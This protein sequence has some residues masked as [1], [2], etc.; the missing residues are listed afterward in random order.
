MRRIHRGLIKRI[1]REFHVWKVLEEEFHS[2]LEYIRV[3]SYTEKSITDIL[4]QGLKAFHTIYPCLVIEGRYLMIFD[5]NAKHFAINK[6]W[7][8]HLSHPRAQLA[9]GDAPVRL[10]HGRD[11]IVFVNDCCIRRDGEMIPVIEAGWRLPVVSFLVGRYGLFQRFGLTRD[12]VVK[13]SPAMLGE[14]L[15]WVLLILAAR[16]ARGTESEVSSIQVCL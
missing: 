3:I 7:V 14:K 8:Y 11:R 10:K 16:G 9:C 12:H 2:I 4:K 15:D 13:S 6:F 1:D 5:T